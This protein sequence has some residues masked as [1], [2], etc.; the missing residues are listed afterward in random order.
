MKH[1]LFVF[2]ICIF[3]ATTFTG[4]DKAQQAIDGIDKAKT[5]S[6]DLQKKAKEIIPG[7]SQKEGDSKEGESGNKGKKEKKEKDD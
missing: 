7:A 5:F 6:N 2:L 1:L 3:L 4:C